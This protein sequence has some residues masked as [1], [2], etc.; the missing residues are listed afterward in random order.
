M[1]VEQFANNAGSTLV[2]SMLAGDSSLVVVSAATFPTVPQFR[3]T[4]DAEIMLVT[5][6][7]GSTF[8]VAR[9][10]EGT[11]N[12]G[13]SAGVA[14][15]QLLTAGALKTLVSSSTRIAGT[16]GDSTGAEVL[17]GESNLVNFDE[18][19][20]TTL[21]PT[22]TAMVYTASSTSTLKVRL[23]GTDGNVDG[24]VI[25]TASI[26]DNTFTAH[27]YTAAAISNPTGLQLVKVTLQS[28]SVGV[29]A[30]VK[31]IRIRFSS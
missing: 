21:V 4:V 5:G 18:T 20:M 6:V 14:V 11:T 8:T 25:L 19:L 26:T 7:T 17:V 31:G 10:Q 15:Y 12:T 2:G 13:H 30:Q 27:K 24:T 23:G 28:P 16:W 9:G 1:S 3:I 22:L 29:N